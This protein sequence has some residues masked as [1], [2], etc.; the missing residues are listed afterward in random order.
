M[1]FSYI[2]DLTHNYMVVRPQGEGEDYALRMALTQKIDGLLPVEARMINDELFLYYQ[3]DSLL[4]LENKSLVQRPGRQA[5]K[6]LFL[7][8]LR[9][10]HLLQDYLIGVD[11]LYLS[12]ETVF[13]NPA[14]DS[15]HFICMPF[16]HR[17][18]TLDAFCEALLSV[19]DP[20][21]SDAIAD[22]YRICERVQEG[23]VRLR[24]LVCL[25][26]EGEEEEE[27]DLYTQGSSCRTT[28]KDMSVHLQ[29]G[30][31]VNMRYE[32][33]RR[34][35]DWAYEG[36]PDAGDAASDPAPGTR[37][38]TKKRKQTVRPGIFTLLFT[39][40]L[41]ADLY[42]RKNYILTDAGNILSLVVGAVCLAGAVGSFVY[43][44]RMKRPRDDFSDAGWSEAGSYEL[45]EDLY[46]G[47]DAGPAYEDAVYADDDA[48]EP[49]ETVLLSYS[50]NRRAHKLY[51][52]NSVNNCNIALDRLPLTLGKLAGRVDLQLRDRSV[53]RV[54]AHINRDDDGGIVVK[55][56]NSTNGT[57]LNGIR[58][59]PN[60]SVRIRT[61]DEICFGNMVFEYL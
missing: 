51:G 3:T 25:L 15:W 36:L 34:N 19:L 37:D 22:A 39:A 49:E 33:G 55:D 10:E 21:D 52:R 53:S 57:F 9:M 28:G 20:E 31:A 43:G 12:P 41:I 5:L 26:T 16:P 13:T 47:D 50:K 24:D 35:E 17:Q 32:D 2:R 59:R 8:L 61:G 60:E 42:I 38:D 56:M 11:C 6:E 44:C 29:K 58:L 46:E 30:G 14:D 27:T 48:E 23:N 1:E 4:S 45:W 54:H 7:A 40:V 18:G